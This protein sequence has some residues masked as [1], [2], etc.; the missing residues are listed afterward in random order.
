MERCEEGR[1]EGG[2]NVEGGLREG[3]GVVPAGVKSM[4]LTSCQTAQTSSLAMH[5]SGGPPRM[6]V[7][8]NIRT[9][10][11]HAHANSCYQ[12]TSHKL[13]TYVL[14]QSQRGSK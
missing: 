1:K 12:Y 3:W 11:P 4:M 8:M 10:R 14:K 5:P 9:K 2:C 6:G 7:V 13:G